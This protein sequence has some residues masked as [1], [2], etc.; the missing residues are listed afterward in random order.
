M[1]LFYLNLKMI[2]AYFVSNGPT[3][4]TKYSEGASAIG[5]Q[6][7]E[8]KLGVQSQGSVDTTS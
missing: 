7:I 2:Q 4:Q 6:S 5:V 1:S 8:S 3:G